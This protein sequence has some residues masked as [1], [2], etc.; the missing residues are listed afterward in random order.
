M[1]DLELAKKR[2]RNRRVRFTTCVCAV[3][4]ATMCIVAF[5]GRRVGTFS[6][7]LDDDGV[8][9]TMDTKESFENPTSYLHAKGVTKITGPYSYTYFETHEK[10]SFDKLDDENVESPQ[11]KKG[12]QTGMNFFKYTFYLKNNGKNKAA[13]DLNVNLLENIKPSNATYALDEYLRVMIIEDGEQTTYAKRSLKNFEKDKE[14]SKEGKCGNDPE[15][16]RKYRG[17]AE[18][19]VN[20]TVLATKVNTLEINEIRKYTIIFWLEGEDPE[21]TVPPDNA[22]L[23]LGVTINGYMG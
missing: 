21:C 8:S 18:L 13:Y 4:V 14:I 10:Y 7:K 2:K 3:G 22:S 20:D 19:F 11:V 6:V 1:Y 9:L 12:D 15:N 17:L 5:L 16:E 23:R